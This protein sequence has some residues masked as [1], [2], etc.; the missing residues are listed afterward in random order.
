KR[1]IGLPGETVAIEMGE[2]AV[3]GRQDIDRWGVG[4]T[5]PDGEWVTLDDHVFVLSDNR[6]TTR[7]DSR[8]F[9]PIPERVLRRVRWRLRRGRRDTP[10]T[11]DQ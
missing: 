9:G 3:D 10:G 2:V 4:F 5:Y 7:D 1:V 11:L 6:K 8:N